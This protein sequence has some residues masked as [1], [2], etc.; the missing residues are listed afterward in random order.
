MTFP[1]NVKVNVTA[2]T[3]GAVLT[4][5]GNQT[6]T[7]NGTVAAAGTDQS[8]VA[9]NLV[10]IGKI[11]LAQNAVGYDSDLSSQYVLTGNAVN[12]GI[13]GLATAVKNNGN[14]EASALNVV[15]TASN[16]FVVGGNV[17]LADNAANCA[18]AIAGSTVPIT[19]LNAAGPVTVTVPT[20]SMLGGAG[21]FGITGTNPVQVCYNVPSNATIA[22]S[23][24]SAVATLAKS[25]A[26]TNLNEQNNV[27]N[28]NLYSLGGGIKIDVRNYASSKETS[29]YQSVIRLINNS[30]VR[31]ADVWGQI[32]HQDGKF[33][34]WG[35]I[36][37]LAPRAVLNLTAA[38]VDALMTNTPN[39]G[40]AANN[41][42]VPSAA[43]ATGAPRL[44]ITS[45]SGSTLRVQNYLFNSATGQILEGSGSQGVDYDL[46]AGRTPAPAT[47]GQLISQD[48]ESGLNGR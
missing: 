17:F 29:G 39:N 12:S 41:G 43:S 37:D 5:G 19:A 18:V 32:I 27:C 13:V 36:T 2:A 45:N 23:S 48:A 15:V 8:F 26:G 35:K 1:T 16:G 9:A 34:G 20:G 33:G 3:G 31:T 4:P 42:S 38:Q 22:S 28:G 46:I 44:R 40:T 14:V 7:N 47:D 11:T 25:A 21:V 6:F 30:D 10:N 24:F